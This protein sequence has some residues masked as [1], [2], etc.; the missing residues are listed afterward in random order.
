MC[1]VNTTILKRERRNEIYVQRV[2]ACYRRDRD[3]DSERIMSCA[4][5]GWKRRLLPLHILQNTTVQYS[6]TLLKG[7]CARV[8]SFNK[9][10]KLKRVYVYNG[11]CTESIAYNTR[12]MRMEAS[13][14]C[15][16][17]MEQLGQRQKQRQ[18]QIWKRSRICSTSS[19]PSLRLLKEE[20]QVISLRGDL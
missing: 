1:I 4:Q 13:S 6:T 7:L 8:L 3:I 18:R 19:V 2:G 10:H 11:V 20:R 12:K 17:H 16:V 9:Q 14:R 15:R 5:V